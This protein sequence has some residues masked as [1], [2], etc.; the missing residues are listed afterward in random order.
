MLHKI[1]LKYLTIVGTSVPS[2]RLFFKA[3]QIDNQQ[4]NRMKVKDL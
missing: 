3:V 4:R 2:E 1:A